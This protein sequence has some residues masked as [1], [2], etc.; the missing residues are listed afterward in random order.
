MKKKLPLLKEYRLDKLISCLTCF[1]TF[2]FNRN[3]QRDC[4]LSKYVRSKPDNKEHWD[5]SVFRGM[6][7]PSLKYLELLYGQKDEHLLT[8]N[9]KL[10]IESRKFD[11]Q[12]QD[13][14]LRIIIYDIDQ[15]IFGF[16]NNLSKNYISKVDFES[17]MIEEIIG[18]KIK[19]KKERINK[20][21]SLLNQVGLIEG[22]REI[23]IN[24]SNLEVVLRKTELVSRDIEMFK[25]SLFNAYNKLASDT[26]GIVK[27]EDLRKAVLLDYLSYKKMILISSIFDEILRKIPLST[28]DYMISFGKPMGAR[29]L[30]FNFSGQY[31]N[32]IHIKFI[33]IHETR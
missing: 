33:D 2:L 24:E 20:W 32:T 6:V 15:N 12:L 28:A 18:E 31:F 14:V 11:N 16:I 30:L 25:N 26:A 29:E 8:A 7:I 27:I 19:P 4:V 9:G 21:L 22:N 23:R 1:D 10:L 17:L 13:T 5:K 3:K